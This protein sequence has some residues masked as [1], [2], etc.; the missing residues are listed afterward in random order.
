MKEQ[1]DTKDNTWINEW[2]CNLL[3]KSGS[4]LLQWLAKSL[5]RDADY[6]FLTKFHKGIHFFTGLLTAKIYLRRCTKVGKRTRTYDGRP[7]IDNAGAMFLGDDVIIN[8]R[9]VRSDFVT[10][11]GGVLE[12][13]NQIH[14]NFGASFVAERQIKIGDG[15]HFG[16][17]CFILDSNAHLIQGDR[18][19]NA[20]GDPIVIEDDVW[21]ASRVT[22]LKGSFIGKGSTIAAGSVVSGYIPPYTIA[23]GVPARV[24]KYLN[25]PEGTEKQLDREQADNVISTHV[26]CGVNEVIKD[27]LNIKE[28][29]VENWNPST[30]E[31][32][33]SF[34]HLQL[35]KRL[36]KMFE[37]E[38]TDKDIIKMNSVKKIYRV[39]DDKYKLRVEA[40]VAGYEI[41]RS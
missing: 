31:T 3:A 7:F 6:S 19:E 1:V 26:L 23:G 34:K 11:P 41:S 15:C 10:R 29:Q 32:W 21:L 36:E 27:M 4:P 14:I 2:I 40:P 22:V 28:Y 20:P 17:Y 39:I 24:I 5:K 16:P 33:D 38:F 8:S 13:G 30:D 12:I 35:I 37:M 9:N 18:F 25:P